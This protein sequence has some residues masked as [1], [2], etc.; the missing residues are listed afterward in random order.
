VPSPLATPAVP[1]YPSIQDPGNDLA[2]LRA[3]VTQLKE[4]VEL[5]T[6]QRASRGTLQY[7]VQGT[8]QQ[9]EQFGSRVY[10]VSI[11]QEGLAEHITLVET[12]A[13]D[14]NTAA[15]AAQTT[16]DDALALAEDITVQGQ[17]VLRSELLPTGYKAYFGVYLKASADSVPGTERRAGFALGLTN[18]DGAYANFEVNQFV[19]R[20]PGSGAAA[21]VFDYAGGFFTFTGSVIINGNLVVDGSIS[22][23]KYGDLSISTA[24]L[25]ELVATTA[26]INY[27]AANQLFQ[28]GGSPAVGIPENTWTT[29][30]AVTVVGTPGGYV[31]F[32]G[33]IGATQANGTNTASRAEGRVIRSDGVVIK[34]PF[35]IGLGNF[36]VYG[37]QPLF[38]FSGDGSQN[39]DYFFQAWAT[40]TNTNYAPVNVYASEF[41]VEVRKR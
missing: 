40:R 30:S 23:T 33:Q 14:A 20:D 9:L 1:V 19:I 31:F 27:N 11:A 24:K 28:A 18:T 17:V 25:A 4:A 22:T 15:G 41:N 35:T 34:G 16:A 36:G 7:S 13:N 6:G 3:T 26:K 5:L 38:G 21:T 10:E 37:E 12:T 29:V 2:S 8:L 32:Q 39:L